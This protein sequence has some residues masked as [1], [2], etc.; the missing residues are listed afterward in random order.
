MRTRRL[1][2]ISVSL[3]L[4]I[5]FFGA[6][7][8]MPTAQAQGP[9]ARGPFFRKAARAVAFNGDLRNLRNAQGLKSPHVLP[10]RGRILRAGS[11][12]LPSNLDNLKLETQQTAPNMPSPIQNFDG[13]S[14]TGIGWPPDT[15][16]D[17]GP[18]D[19]V[20]A[21]NVSLA[22]YN[23]SGAL[24][25]GPTTFDALF[26]PL[27]TSTPCGNNNQGDP[28]VLYDQLADRWLVSDFA[29]AVDL[30]GNPQAPFYQCIAVSK[31][32]DPVTGGWY[33][34]SLLADNTLLNDYPKF[35]LW[36][37]AYYMTANMYDLSTNDV[38]VRVWALDRN[39][40]LNGSLNSVYFDLP[41]CP[42]SASTCSVY[43]L[44]PSNLRG[45]LPPA[46]SPN[47]LAN[48]E[49]A[50][51][52]TAIPF[53]SNVIHFWKF[54]LNGSW[55]APPATLT[56]PFNVSVAPFLEA[57]WKSGSNIN[58]SLVP[59]KGTSTRLDTL[60]DRLMMQLQYRNIG[61]A[62]SLWASHTVIARTPAGLVTGIRWYQVR[63]ASGG[64]H[65]AQ[66]GQY[67]PNDGILRWMPSL[68]VDQKGDM[69][70][71]FSASNSNNYPS[72]RYAGRLATD[73][74]GQLAQGESVLFSGS[75]SQ[76]SYPL[77]GAITRWGDYSAMTIDPTDD[78][79]F[80]Y[81]NEYY[82]S[83]GYKWRTR[84]GSTKFPG[85]P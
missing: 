79:T 70:V 4:V 28:V 22:V 31:T 83:S 74:A 25:A 5:V 15:N 30:L 20:Q 7:N 60:G 13:V 71:G 16:G 45:A 62:E 49:T 50:N 63:V 8:A 17:V 44:L 80:W 35:G 14:W 55:P 59:Q 54:A 26:A 43:S 72:L 42:A 51:T 38:H 64:F 41:P 47:Y 40:M 65:L 34:Y 37:D 19:Y 81:T 23:K 58:M 33:L 76:T 56:G 61:G 39:A 53:V 32:S 11:I 12:S 24:L 67:T 48:I 68:A 27:G 77:I 6:Q 1:I 36:P 75:G 21:V 52:T 2:A 57:L 66:Q 29:F 78:C 3:L 84:I 73:P 82:A 10:L 85:C 9:S 18:N 69:V 46:G